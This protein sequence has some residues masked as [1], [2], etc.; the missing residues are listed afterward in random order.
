MTAASPRHVISHGSIILLK[1][2]DEYVR[3]LSFH[4][5]ISSLHRHPVGLAGVFERDCS[6]VS[7]QECPEI[8]SAAPLIALK[9]VQLTAQT[10]FLA[11]HVQPPRHEGRIFA[12]RT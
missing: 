5:F 2:S 4:T 11:P 3:E 1:L 12:S 8:P 7:S 6:C 9:R 10:H